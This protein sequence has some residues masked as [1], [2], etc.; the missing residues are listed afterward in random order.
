MKNEAE[1]RRDAL[2]FEFELDAPLAKVWRALT[3]PEYV[4]RWLT[5]P[6]KDAQ[7]HKRE[8][9]SVAPVQ[10]LA[11]SPRGLRTSAVHSIQLDRQRRLV[12]RKF[13]DISRV[14]Q[15]CRRHHVPAS[16]TNGSSGMMY[17]AL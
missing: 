2:K 5:V 8:D 12:A 16:F 14:S 13:G 4:A 15:P 11:P 1:E 10:A 17:G 6:A 9:P 7:T 3:I